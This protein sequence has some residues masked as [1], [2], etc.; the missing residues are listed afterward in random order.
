MHDFGQF[1]DNPLESPLD[2]SF[3]K[4]PL[5]FPPNALGPDAAG[6]FSP[7]DPLAAM[8]LKVPG[9]EEDYFHMDSLGKLLT[10]AEAAI[11]NT[12]AIPPTS[13]IDHLENS[14]QNTSIPPEAEAKEVQLFKGS[15]WGYSSPPIGSDKTTPPPLGIYDEPSTRPAF[16]AN[17]GP[18]T[19]HGGRIRNKYGGDDK[20]WCPLEDDFI[21]PQICQNQDC[22]HYNPE[23][24]ACMHY[25]SED[26]SPDTPDRE[27]NDSG[28][29][30]KE[31]FEF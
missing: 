14:I 13:P 3:L 5:D 21:S 30:T 6:N 2:G 4:D 18:I 12:P 28:Y 11:E 7:S 20:I 24:R 15:G 23:T 27:T 29:V 26:F 22:E 25:D 19:Q 17:L 16:Y 10:D 1:P 31:D 8:N 9:A